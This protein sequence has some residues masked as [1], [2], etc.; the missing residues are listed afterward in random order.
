M[1]LDVKN[2]AMLVTD[3][4][5]RCENKRAFSIGSNFSYYC[6]QVFAAECTHDK[7]TEV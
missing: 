6:Q 7:K 1:G 3:F 5:R 2:M 4:K